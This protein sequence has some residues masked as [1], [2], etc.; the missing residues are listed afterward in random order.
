VKFRVNDYDFLSLYFQTLSSTKF[1]FNLMNFFRKVGY[2]WWK[3]F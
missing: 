1:I 2:L 3:Y